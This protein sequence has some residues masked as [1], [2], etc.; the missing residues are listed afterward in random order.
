M[1]NSS[2]QT[3]NLILSELEESGC[4]RR[5]LAYLAGAGLVVSG[6]AAPNITH[7][8]ASGTTNRNAPMPVTLKLGKMPDAVKP[9]Q[10]ISNVKIRVTRSDK[11][12]NHFKVIFAPGRGVK[13]VPGLHAGLKI[14]GDRAHPGDRL[15]I[16]DPR[17]AA[18]KN[19]TTL[20]FSAQAPE[21]PNSCK[22]GQL[23]FEADAS[24]NA[25]FSVSSHFVRLN[26]QDTDS[27][28]AEWLERLCDPSTPP[29]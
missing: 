9:G 6:F 23:G 20:F 28:K 1:K 24:T 14:V 13:K 22:E 3:G 4:S 16:F 19:A 7:S 26:I 21:R 18:G 15:A 5:Y 17:F 11:R 2:D 8:D 25:G 12:I 10:K 29:N 27:R